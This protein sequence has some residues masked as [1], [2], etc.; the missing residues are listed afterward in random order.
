MRPGPRKTSPLLTFLA[1]RLGKLHI[2]GVGGEYAHPPSSAPLRGGGL[3]RTLGQA[4]DLGRGPGV[5]IG[6]SRHFDACDECIFL[7]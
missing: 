3:S 6:R 4:R 7:G 2:L 5:A 1:A